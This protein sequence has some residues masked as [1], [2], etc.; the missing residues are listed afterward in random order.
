MDCCVC[1]IRCG[2]SLLGSMLQTIHDW[3]PGERGRSW[4]IW[5]EA[6]PSDPCLYGCNCMH[7][8]VCV[9]VCVYRWR[10]GA[11]EGM[12]SGQSDFQM[13]PQK[14]AI[15]VRGRA[16]R[17]RGKRVYNTAQ[18]WQL[19]QTSFFVFGTVSA[20]HPLFMNGTQT[21]FSGGGEGLNPT[22]G[23]ILKRMPIKY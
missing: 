4:L 17:W 10:V 21:R 14:H 8:C 15:S 12:V 6:L 7:V 13:P 20:H 23:A 2:S 22:I 5:M 16:Q 19:V 1:V 18:A 9:C 11:W 3:A